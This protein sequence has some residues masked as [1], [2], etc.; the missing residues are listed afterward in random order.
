MLA[1]LPQL[2]DHLG[3]SFDAPTEI[4]ALQALD[5]ASSIVQTYT[6]QDF[7]EA[8]T[9]ETFIYGVDR[10]LRLSQRPVTAVTS[11]TV[12]GIPWSADLWDFTPDGWIYEPG[13]IIGRWFGSWRGATV[14]VTYT[15]GYPTVPG[16]IQFVCLTLAARALENPTMQARESIG[17]ADGTYAQTGFNL[18]AGGALT[19]NE[20]AILDTFRGVVVA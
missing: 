5:I 12:D 16:A 2:E 7:T 4:R 6:G 8:T 10:V 11:V 14:S 19:K 20:E 18:G 1:T 3:Q 15:H 17:S 9:S 13:G